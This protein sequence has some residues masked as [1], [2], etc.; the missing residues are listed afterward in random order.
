[1]MKKKR[2]KSKRYF[3]PKGIINNYVIVNGKIFY[4]QAIDSD[5]KRYEEIR[6]LI[7]AQGE[8][9]TAGCLLDYDYIKNHYIFIAVDLSRQ[10]R[11][12]AVNNGKLLR[13]KSYTNKYTIKQIK[14][15]SNK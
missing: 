9:Y 15:C 7:A 4:D 3:L 2:F 12:D 13:S 6:K 14:I 8:D 1:M 5:I 10:N 11:L